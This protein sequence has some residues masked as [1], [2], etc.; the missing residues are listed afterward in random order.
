VDPRNSKGKDTIIDGRCETV[1]PL[2]KSVGSCP[3][4]FCCDSMTVGVPPT[5]R[6]VDA[7][8]ESEQSSQYTAN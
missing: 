4:F 7:G 1:C 6:N 3:K 2:I 8:P 5:S